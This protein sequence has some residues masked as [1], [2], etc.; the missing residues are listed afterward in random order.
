MTAKEMFHEEPARKAF[1]ADKAGLDWADTVVLLLPAG[2]S[3]HLEAGYA[4][5]Q[6][7]DLFILGPP[8]PGE[9]DVMYGFARVVCEGVPEL[10]GALAEIPRGGLA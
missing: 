8:V 6:G 3:S 5:G 9:F 4:V 2:R 7:K 10:I 1:E